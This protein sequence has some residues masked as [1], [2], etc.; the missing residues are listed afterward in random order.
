MKNMFNN[1]KDKLKFFEDIYADVN[2]ESLIKYQ[3]IKVKEEISKR[4]K[5]MPGGCLY[6]VSIWC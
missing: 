4:V 6:L 1:V 3:E 5:S 2:S